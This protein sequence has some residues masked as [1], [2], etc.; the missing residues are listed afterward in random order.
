MNYLSAY[1]VD[2]LIVQSEC[3]HLYTNYLQWHKKQDLESHA[4]AFMP[5][6]E[7]SAHV[8]QL[9]WKKA[10]AGHMQ[11]K[12]TRMNRISPKP[13]ISVATRRKRR[14]LD[15]QD[16]VLIIQRS[17]RRHNVCTVNQEWY[18][19]PCTCIVDILEWKLCFLVCLIS[20]FFVC[21]RQENNLVTHELSN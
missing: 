14:I 19:H 15:V 6:E 2:G 10:R 1:N 7:Y 16:A 21:S 13:T 12:E 5:L 20:Y 11:R 8:I 18:S 9:W 4:A 17:W 3:P